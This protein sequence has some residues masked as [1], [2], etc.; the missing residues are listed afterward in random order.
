[1]TSRERLLAALTGKIPDRLPV[2]THHVLTCYLKEQ[3]GGRSSTEFFDYFGLDP[4]TC[5][6][7]I[8]YL[9]RTI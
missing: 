7:A 5:I 4:F 9:R 3:F 6:V 8:S 2:T 1:M